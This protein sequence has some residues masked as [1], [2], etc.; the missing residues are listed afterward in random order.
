MDGLEEVG[1]GDGIDVVTV[2]RFLADGGL[3]VLSG[4]FSI[5]DWP[6]HSSCR[7]CHWFCC[8][9]S[10]N[11]RDRK[12]IIML[13]IR[14]P[15]RHHLQNVSARSTARA[16]ERTTPLP[17]VIVWLSAIRADV[18][19]FHQVMNE[20]LYSFAFITWHSL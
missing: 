17:L 7:R 12:H 1:V 5:K 15:I 13:S 6:V 11:S 16:R 9:R 14:P 2:V 19:L 20:V 18:D 4:L 10:A 3:I 8:E